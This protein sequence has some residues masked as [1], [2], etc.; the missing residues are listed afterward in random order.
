MFLFNTNF[1]KSTRDFDAE[2]NEDNVVDFLV[3]KAEEHGLLNYL[4]ILEKQ[5]RG[6]NKQVLSFH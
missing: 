4:K 3:R 6:K 5:I 1:I 2:F